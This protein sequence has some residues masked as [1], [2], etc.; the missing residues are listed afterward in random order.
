[1]RRI[2]CAVAG[3]ALALFAW[4]G[5]AAQT[6]EQQAEWDKVV[7]AAKQEGTVTLYSGQLGVPYHPEIARLF[8]EK[9]GIPVEIL[10]GRASE[11]LERIRTEQTTGRIVGDFSHSGGFSSYSMEKQGFYQPHGWL[12]NAHKLKKGFESDGTRVPIYVQPY[13]ILVN[14]N[15]VPESERPKSW[16]DLLDPKWKGK[17]LADDFR[18]LGG[19]GLFFDVTYRTFGREYH[20]QLVK[21]DIVFS[22]QI[23][24]NP[25][26]VARGEFLIYIPLSMPDMLMNE[27]L[28]I[29]PISPEEGLMYVVYDVAVFNG[30]SHPNASKLLVNFFLEDEAQAVYA[31]SGRG[32]TIEGGDTNIP[33]QAGYLRDMK[34]LGQSDVERTQEMLQLATEI[35]G[36]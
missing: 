35:Y 28:P 24:E 7:E 16:K 33:E 14:S 30:A 23:R 6:A 31:R 5:A 32:T 20:D 8:T 25:R 21:Q 18:A 36:R 19:G 2:K 13:G 9:Y 15:L 1:M 17:I 4:N 3:V 34:L 12:P 10:E 22:R 27:G 29:T 11:I 26:R